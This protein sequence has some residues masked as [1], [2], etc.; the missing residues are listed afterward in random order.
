MMFHMPPYIVAG[1]AGADLEVLN[2][3]S[4]PSYV[5]AY[6]RRVGRSS[7]PSYD[8]YVAFNF[9]RLAAILHGIKG[10]AVRGT[11][12]SAHAQERAQWF[13][14]LAKLAWIQA[15]RAP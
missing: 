4:E 13:P 8:F 3:P 10:R 2:I 6:C 11:A 15:Q 7:I 1:L 5:E 14:E 9:F 12:A